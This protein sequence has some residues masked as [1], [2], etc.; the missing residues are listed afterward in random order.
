MVL[1]VESSYST[2][3]QVSIN[4][5]L[6]QLGYLSKLSLYKLNIDALM[7]GGIINESIEKFIAKL[8]A[9]KP[10]FHSKL[11]L[12]FMKAEMKRFK[13]HWRPRIRKLKKGK[14]KR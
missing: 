13:K 5:R 3:S 8:D 10:E 9:F 1:C 6:K 12:K 2:T 7:A 14:R 11:F 4:L